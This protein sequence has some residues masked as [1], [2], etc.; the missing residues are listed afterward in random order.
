MEGYIDQE[1]LSDDFVALIL[2]LFKIG[3]F[4]SN[5][6]S[7]IFSYGKAIYNSIDDMIYNSKNY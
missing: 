3:P 7:N 4:I 5:A 6:R 2:F 1:G